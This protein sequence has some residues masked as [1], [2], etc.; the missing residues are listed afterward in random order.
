MFKYSERPD[1]KAARKYSDDVPD[2]VKTRRLNEVI[3]LQNRLSLRSKQKDVGR[4]FEV[5]V[6]GYSKKSD[7]DLSGRTSQNKVVVFP[8]GGQ[9]PGDYVKVR[10]TRCTSAT[11]IGEPA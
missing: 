1:T 10:I 9:K 2:E 6:E 3:A 5:L 7:K 8:S 11:L 4:I